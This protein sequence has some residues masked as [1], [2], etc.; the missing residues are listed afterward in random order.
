MPATSRW[1]GRRESRERPRRA[2]P[3][4]GTRAGRRA[5][6]ERALNVHRLD[7]RQSGEMP[8]LA[9]LEELR[10]VV[11]Q[12]V[13]AGL[14][15]AVAGW[16]LAPRVLENLIRGTVGHAVV[17]SPLEAFNERFKLS[18]IIGLLLAG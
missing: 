10:K 16:M 14:I 8:F 5:T 12:V 18:L 6:E 9:H 2:A 11:V 13:A 4:F 15:G 7:P 17:L 1:R 3:A